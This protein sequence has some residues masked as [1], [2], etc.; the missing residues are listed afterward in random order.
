MKAAEKSD[1]M[2][3]LKPYQQII[4]DELK[5]LSFNTEIPLFYEPIHYFL[6]IP[7]KRIRPLL[8]LLAAEMLGSSSERA[9]FAAT[10]VELLHNFTL[11]HD[12]IMDND[13][14]RR[15]Q[16]T[17]HKKWDISTAILAG[18]GLMGFAFQELLKTPSVNVADMARR[19]TDTMIVICEGQGQDKMFEDQEQVAEQAYQE[20][21]SRKTA[22]L[23][24]LSCELG[25]MA[26]EANEKTIKGLSEFGYALGMGF[27][28]QDDLLDVMGDSSTIG[29]AVGSDLSMHK[30]TLLTIKLQKHFPQK[31][32]FALP[33]KEFRELLKQSGVLQEVQNSYKNHFEHAY[34]ILEDQPDNSAKELLSALIGFIQ[35]RQW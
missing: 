17:I 22:V 34:Q 13:D 27:Q 29:K 28:I 10:A 7:G 20:M 32:L 8:V 1:L 9:R 31:D 24:Q 30:Q 14:T 33:I 6:A 25:A 35:N 19:F 12:D 2:A 3:R 11:V 5:N 16:L 4:E 15:G 26:A 21:I 18:D 23:L